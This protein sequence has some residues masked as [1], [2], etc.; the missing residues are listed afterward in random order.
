MPKIRTIAQVRKA[1]DRYNRLKKAKDHLLHSM[2]KRTLLNSE[3]QE[4]TFREFLT[5]LK[6]KNVNLNKLFRG[7]LKKFRNERGEG[8]VWECPPVTQKT[9]DDNFSFNL[10][11]PGGLLEEFEPEPEIYREYYGREPSKSV[12]SFNSPNHNLL[13]VPKPTEV[14]EQ[15]LAKL[16]AEPESTF[17]LSTSGLQV[18]AVEEKFL[19][20]FGAEFAVSLL[21]GGAW[22]ALDKDLD[23][24]SDPFDSSPGF[25]E[26]RERFFQTSG[27]LDKIAERIKKRIETETSRTT[28]IGTPLEGITFEEI[29]RILPDT[30]TKAQFKEL[31][32]SK[33]IGIFFQHCFV[34]EWEKLI[35]LIESDPNKRFSSVLRQKEK[36][37]LSDFDLERF[38]ALT[39][40]KYLFIERILET[41]PSE[42][43]GEPTDDEM[44][45]LEGIKELTNLET[46]R[47]ALEEAEIRGCV[48]K[49]AL[50]E[51]DKNFKK[52]FVK[53]Q[54][55]GFTKYQTFIKNFFNLG[56]NKT[57]AIQQI[58]SFIQLNNNEATF[59]KY[60]VDN[61]LPSQEKDIADEIATLEKT[62][63]Y[64][65]NK[66]LETIIKNASKLIDLEKDET[67]IEDAFFAEEFG[68]RIP[69]LLKNID[70]SEALI[71]IA[72]EI[73]KDSEK[74]Q[75]DIIRSESYKELQR[76]LNEKRSN[77]REIKDQRINRNNNRSEVV[78]KLEEVFESLAIIIL[79]EQEAIKLTS[80]FDLTYL[81]NLKTSGFKHTSAFK[82]KLQ[83][84]ENLKM[85]MGC[86][87][88]GETKLPESYG[89]VG[90]EETYE[91]EEFG[92]G[93]GSG[94]S[95][96]SED[97]SR[98]GFPHRTAETGGG[99][100][101]L[102][103]EAEIEKV[104]NGVD[105]LTKQKLSVKVGV[106][107][108]KIDQKEK[109]TFEKDMVF[110]AGLDFDTCFEE[111]YS[112]P[113]GHDEQYREL[114]KKKSPENAEESEEKINLEYFENWFKDSEGDF[115]FE[116]IQKEIDTYLNEEEIPA[117]EAEGE[118]A[119]LFEKV[120]NKPENTSPTALNAWKKFRLENAEFTETILKGIEF[121]SKLKNQEFGSDEKDTGGEREA[122]APRSEEESEE[123]NSSDKETEKDTNHSPAFTEQ[124]GKRKIKLA[125]EN[126]EKFSEWVGKLLTITGITEAE[127]NKSIEEYDNSMQMGERQ[128]EKRKNAIGDLIHVTKWLLSKKKTETKEEVGERNYI[129]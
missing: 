76:S 7:A 9:L 39:I 118:I 121:Y 58:C 91:R 32:D 124:I 17:C 62:P 11:K 10:Y 12:V 67:E 98:G 120:K 86:L 14:A 125:T 104:I 99:S 26:A 19:D 13:V 100:E 8:F 116:N 108:G 70:N 4:L 54:E 113:A 5:N 47:T 65:Q 6:T 129:L 50:A 105:G 122:D 95:R 61:L 97:R 81:D 84:L 96:A 92:G 43:T 56:L 89:R 115:I 37:I 101:E 126:A 53:K 18:A 31:A 107:W 28:F 59:D 24:S 73:I 27:K 93:E 112:S 79:E 22:S 82:S 20:D 38:D 45:S 2:D 29:N 103:Y 123:E 74:A 106:D 49:E 75:G 48:L 78:K 66:K 85:L 16:E 52:T 80:K 25:K 23:Y 88:R 127:L 64:K 33:E 3:E 77:L 87:E 72:K 128:K 30:F 109:T 94:G 90:S 114:L 1:L 55:N 117:D 102:D 46:F 34:A 21:G 69:E 15:M 119:A 110:P 40:R 57:Q 35:D 42:I 111:W 44:D 63:Q 51:R 60:F 36:Q 83:D 71:R 41:F 68:E